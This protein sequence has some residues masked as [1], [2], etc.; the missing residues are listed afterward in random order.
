[1]ETGKN[2]C[3]TVVTER[4]KE[5][6]SESCFDHTCLFPTCK[7]HHPGPTPTPQFWAAAHVNNFDASNAHYL[8]KVNLNIFQLKHK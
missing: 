5:R 2:V 3:V 1:L 4:E 7:S 8:K 6:E